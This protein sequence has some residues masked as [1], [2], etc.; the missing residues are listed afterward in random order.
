[1]SYLGVSCLKNFQGRL[2][3]GLPTLADGINYRDAETLP[4]RSSAQ[5]LSRRAIL[6]WIPPRHMLCCSKSNLGGCFLIRDN[7]SI[8]KWL[9][10]FWECKEHKNQ[11]LSQADVDFSLSWAMSLGRF[12]FTFLTVIASLLKWMMTPLSQGYEA[13]L[14]EKAWVRQHGTWDTGNIHNMATAVTKWRIKIKP[15]LSRDAC[16]FFVPLEISWW[17]AWAH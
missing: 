4:S 5:A 7:Y 14:N 16:C 8:I 13:S 12:H 3:P 11:G 9:K 6:T 15:G 17:T 1:M 2:V 10:S